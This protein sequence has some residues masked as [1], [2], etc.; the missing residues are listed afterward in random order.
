M[1]QKGFRRYILTITGIV[2]FDSA[3]ARLEKLEK[4]MT[5]ELGAD[6]PIREMRIKEVSD[7]TIA[8]IELKS[9]DNIQIAMERI[10]E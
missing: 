9:A 3:D 6:N 7:L 10:L 4:L 1:E 2:E 5:G 8:L